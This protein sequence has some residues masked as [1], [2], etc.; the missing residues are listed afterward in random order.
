VLPLLQ[1]VLPLL[2]LVLP[3]QPLLLPLLLLRPLCNN[4]VR[5][6]IITIITPSS[7]PEFAGT[8][9]TV[10]LSQSGFIRIRIPAE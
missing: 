5:V 10:L 4:K 9:G 2:Q 8:R 6:R 7:L 3:L 1:L